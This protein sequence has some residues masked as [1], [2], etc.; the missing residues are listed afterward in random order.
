MTKQKKQQEKQ[1][2][3][4]RS[5]SGIFI[6]IFYVAYF[7]LLVFSDPNVFPPIENVWQAQFI[8]N[9]ACVLMMVPIVYFVAHEIT[10][11]CFPGHKAVFIYTA[12]ALFVLTMGS[13]IFLLGGRHDIWHFEIG[14][15]F[16][17][18]LEIC[19]A[20]IVFF[21]L[22]S[23]L[24]W[25]IMSRHIVYVG[26]K[27][28]IWYP[29][30]VFILNTF[31]VAFTYTSII[32]GWSAFMFLIMAS[33]GCDLF[34]YLGGRKFGKHKLA[35]TIS[36]N[37]TWEGLICGMVVTLIICLLT[38]AILFIPD[39]E[40]KNHS[41]Y[42]FV[43]CQSCS[44]YDNRVLRNLQPYFW[45]IYVFTFIA[46]MTVSVCGDLF[47]SWVK[48]RFNIKDFSNL[49]PGHGGMLDR[50]DALIFIFTFYFLV[51]VIIQLGMYAIPNDQSGLRFLWT[52]NPIFV[53]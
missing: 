40:H 25:I 36:P 35:P 50:L 10:N 43:G 32:H 27:T 38:V 51:T 44:V 1:T 11:I 49:I 28:R 2:F 4:A 12:L 52:R 6:A 18:Y 23:T 13:S 33:T 45:A 5:R 42:C 22:V 48:R 31:F 8:L 3:L 15:E 21:T 7:L 26:R 24:V 16:V 30:L 19:L 14:D 29:L 46:L 47:F 17:W 39:I 20:G 9:F 37:K 53:F 41:L 34:A